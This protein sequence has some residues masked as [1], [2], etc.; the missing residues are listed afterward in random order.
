MKYDVVIVG[1]GPG[2]LQC[3]KTLAGQGVK[4]LILERRNRIGKKVCAGGI[5]WRGLI[6]TV[7]EEL[8]ERTFHRQIITTRYQRTVVEERVPM[9]ATIDRSVLGSY[10]E[11]QAAAAGA[12]IIT[13]AHVE[14]VDGNRISYR[15]NHSRSEVRFDYLVGADGSNSR[16][17]KS[18]GLP[19]EQ[20]ERGVGIHY[21][22]EDPAGELDMVWNFDSDLFHSGY[23]WIFPH[24]DT[25]SVGAYIGT[26]VR[27]AQELKS[28]LEKWLAMRNID[29]SDS[30]LEAEQIN[31]GYRGWRFDSVF[32]VGDAAGLAS[33]LTGE[34]INPAII[35]GETVARTIVDPNY[36]SSK[37]ERI[38]KCHRNHKKMLQTA[39][40][41]QMLATILSE[42]S[43]LLLR[44]RLISFQ[45]F[46]M[47]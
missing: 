24:R 17:R 4:T 34:G 5:T 16:V 22:V 12:E 45:R 10:M 42:L 15:K 11:Q 6:K 21:T 44:Y 25:A 7:P 1:A 8:L 31:W 47:A 20:S 19:N 28:G 46:E 32:L 35:S 33:P 38:V 41:S 9:V 30:R 27:S 2:G 40:K 39:S 18:L 3:G 26:T 13:G 36:D 14:L 29:Y 37:L 23:S 43:A